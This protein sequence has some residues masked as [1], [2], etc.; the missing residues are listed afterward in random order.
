MT[1]ALRLRLAAL[2]ALFPLAGG[3]SLALSGDFQ[4]KEIVFGCAVALFHGF[5]SALFHRIAIGRNTSKFMLFGVLAPVFMTG[6]TAVVLVW[7]FSHVGF[8]NPDVFLAIGLAGVLCLLAG[9]ILA[10][11]FK[12][13]G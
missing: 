4:K 2:A 5:S 8:A 12:Q 11:H 10:L 3:L 9:E 13:P 1:P 6:L 7:M